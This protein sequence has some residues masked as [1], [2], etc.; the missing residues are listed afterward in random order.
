MY[1]NGALAMTESRPVWLQ[2]VTGHVSS[3]LPLLDP[4]GYAARVAFYYETHRQVV[5]HLQA[6]AQRR[7]RVLFL[8]HGVD[9]ATINND[10]W[11]GDFAQA[12]H[13]QDWR[14]MPH[15][16]YEKKTEQVWGLH[17]H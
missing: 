6:L 11:S 13:T 8:F 15:A 10:S 14:N 17:Q 9:G 1:S 5:H 7:I 4:E 12:V 16:L 2:L 3:P